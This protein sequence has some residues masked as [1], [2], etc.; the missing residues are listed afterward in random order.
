MTQDPASIDQIV[1]SLLAP[2]PM[3]VFFVLVFVAVLLHTKKLRLGREVEYLETSVIPKLEADVKFWRDFS[4]RQMNHTDKVMEATSVLA[5]S[6]NGG[7]Q[8]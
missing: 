7:T 8:P 3:G 4:M 2:G 6:A 1:R 5:K